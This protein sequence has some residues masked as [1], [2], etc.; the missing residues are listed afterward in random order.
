MDKVTE[1]LT[2]MIVGGV[3]MLVFIA[4]LCFVSGL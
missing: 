3:T 4:V 2:D 1:F